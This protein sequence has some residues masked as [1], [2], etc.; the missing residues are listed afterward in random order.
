MLSEEARHPDSDSLITEKR[1]ESSSLLENL[2]RPVTVMTCQG[3]VQRR[4]RSICSCSWR[5]GRETMR[6]ELVFSSKHALE[7]DSSAPRSTPAMRKHPPRLAVAAAALCLAL[8]PLA[9]AYNGTLVLEASTTFLL[10]AIPFSSNCV[11]IHKKNH[12]LMVCTSASHPH[13]C[14]A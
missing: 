4:R 8:L 3:V 13:T 11:T 1:F 7:T 5:I 12:N 14:G 9:Y 10:R 6:Q 2:E